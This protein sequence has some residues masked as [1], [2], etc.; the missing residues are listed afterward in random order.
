MLNQT[1]IDLG[2]F[3]KVPKH[4]RFTFPGLESTDKLCEYFFGRRFFVP[5][6]QPIN[7][8]VINIRKLPELAQREPPSLAEPLK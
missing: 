6:F 8:S 5:C 7:I 3:R 4:I 2:L 1:R